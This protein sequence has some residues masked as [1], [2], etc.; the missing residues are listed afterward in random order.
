MSTP[1]LFL[2]LQVFRNK[3]L[4]VFRN[5][6]AWK[7]EDGYQK[8][9][10]GTGVQVWSEWSRGTVYSSHFFSSQSSLIS[11]LAESP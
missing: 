8:Q 4:Q 11:V 9:T 1:T 6:N 2:Q 5:K 3:K 7:E 10:K